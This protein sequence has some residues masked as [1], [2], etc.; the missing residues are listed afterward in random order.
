[1]QNEI[2]SILETVLPSKTVIVVKEDKKIFDDGKTLQIA[3]YPESNTINNVSGQYPQVVSLRL[4]LDTLELEPQ[5]YG[6]NG[7]R[8][9]YRVPDEKHRYLAMQSIKIPFRRPKPEKDKILAAV[10]RFA[11]RWLQALKDNKEVLKYHDY[12][13]Y[14][15]YF[16]S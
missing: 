7:G 14:D 6:G 5:I 12:V 3:F 10:K 4:D 11:E 1:M 2:K 15:E 16:N 13:N 9:I 8:C